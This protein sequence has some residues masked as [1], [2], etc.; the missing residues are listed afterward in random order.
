MIERSLSFEYDIQYGDQFQEQVSAGDPNPLTGIRVLVG[1]QD[2]GGASGK[3]DT[4]H[5]DDYV[6]YNLANILQKL[7]NAVTSGER[8][9]AT[10]YATNVTLALIPEDDAIH[11]GLFRGSDIASAISSSELVA[12]PRDT[13]VREFARATEEFI[14]TCE[15]INPE[16]RGCDEF[17]RLSALVSEL[18]EL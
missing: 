11:I 8:E 10:F 9:E 18:S 3:T 15:S 17:E 14:R 1:G 12:V 16:L 5:V 13:I 2:L 4:Y 7:K 6:H